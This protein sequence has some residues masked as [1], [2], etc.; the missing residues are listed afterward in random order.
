MQSPDAIAAIR[1]REIKYGRGIV[2]ESYYEEKEFPRFID[3]NGVH[4][5]R[6]MNQ[7]HIKVIVVISQSAAD[8]AGIKIG[9]EVVKVND[10]VIEENYDDGPRELCMLLLGEH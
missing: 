3:E 1:M 8:K 7:N 9:D 2:F 10:I 5:A 6:R 4:E